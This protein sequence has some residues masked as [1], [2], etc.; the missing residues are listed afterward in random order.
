M[1]DLT[2][3]KR[4][5]QKNNR[6]LPLLLIAIAVILIVLA[7]KIFAQS[8]EIKNIGQEKPKTN[9]QAIAN[10]IKEADTKNP[11]VNELLLQKY[12]TE[13]QKKIE[14]EDNYYLGSEQPKITIVEFGDFSCSFCKD[15]YQKIRALGVK[16]KTDIKII[17]RDR[18]AFENSTSQAMAAYCAGEQ[19]YF[20]EMHDKL[21]QNQANNFGDD[22]NLTI[23]AQQIKGIET[24]QF[25][26]CLTDQKYLNKIKKNLTDSEDLSITG[27]PYFF[28]NGEPFVGD[29]PFE[30][31]EAL[32]QELLK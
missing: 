5:K 17:W 3:P 14:G 29:Q 9:N 1:R 15:S 28:V 6:V 7:I 31:W 2:K 24:T 10:D 11:K 13:K 27:T 4:I 20:W 32:I 16:Y 19:G 30:T 25:A 12:T 8:G 18:P 21:F 22:Q 26:Q 23:L